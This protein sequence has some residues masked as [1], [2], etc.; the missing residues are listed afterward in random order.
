MASNA[1]NPRSARELRRDLPAGRR[2]RSYAVGILVFL[3]SASIYAVTFVLTFW[4]TWPLLNL[5]SALANGGVIGL[6]FIIGHDACHGSFTP[7]AVLN[8][9][10]ARLAFLPA[11]QPYTSWVYTHNGLHHGWTNLKGK[12][13]VF[14]PL[15]L[16]EYQTQPRWRQRLERTYRT[17]LGLGLMHLVEVW[18]KFELFPPPGH[19]PKNRWAFH[20]DRLLVLGFLVLKI[21][22]AV[23]LAQQTGV[24]PGGALL[25][26]GLGLLLSYAV[27]FWLI[28]TVTFVQHTHSE[29]PWYDDP[30]EWNFYRGQ[31][32]GSPH[33]AMPF[34]LRKLLHNVM[35]HAAHHVD[36]LI[37]LYRL[38]ASQR[39][40]KRSCQGDLV[41]HTASV[42]G[43]LQILRVCRLYD[44]RRHQWLDFDGTPT[45]RA[46]LNLLAEER[47]TA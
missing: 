34:W 7:S 17:F 44:Y 36:P 39:R 8:R 45:S 6:L 31:V 12:D 29:V 26:A 1:S 42:P 15:T 37:P 10:L 5:A 41:G 13:V 2:E 38:P 9:L 20:A 16:A 25:H 4:P 27:W 3:L 28:G 21:A 19:Q 33:L 46:G 35:D 23:A 11:L 47:R 43:L 24:G 30:R 40:L 32:H 18:W 14:A 22:L